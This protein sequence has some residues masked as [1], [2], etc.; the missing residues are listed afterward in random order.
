MGRLI[1]KKL[2]GI[3][4]NN[5]PS[6]IQDGTLVCIDKRGAYVRIFNKWVPYRWYHKLIGLKP[7][8][9]DTVSG[10]DTSDWKEGDNL[11]VSL[12]CPGGY[13]TSLYEA[14]KNIKVL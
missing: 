1:G 9:F 11:Y 12:D 4:I 13:V 5:S 10:I 3:A 6:D 14:M 7:R 2:I 8:H